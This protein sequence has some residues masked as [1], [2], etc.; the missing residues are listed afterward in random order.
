MNNDPVTSYGSKF[1]HKN[2]RRRVFKMVSVGVMDDAINSMYDVISISA[3][4]LNLSVTIMNT[5]TQLEIRFGTVFN[6]IEAATIAFFAV[7]YFLRLY[8][9]KCLYPAKNEIMAVLSYAISFSGIVDMLSFLPYYLPTFFPAGAAV[10]K[11]FRVARILRLFRIN[12]Y[13]DSLNVI[14]EV[15][16]RKKQQLL[17]SFFIIIV[18]MLAS[19][20]CMYS[21]ENQAQ[22]EVFKDAF[23]GIWWAVSTLLTV[24]YGDIYPITPIGRLMGI[25]IAFLG[26]TIIAIP[27]GIISAGFVEQYS[28][29]Q[30]FDNG[31]EA[32]VHFIKINLIQ[33]DKWIGQKIC[34]L[35]LPRGVIVAVVQ[36]DN[37]TIVPRGNLRLRQGDKLIMGADSIKGDKPV[38]LKEI[39]LKKNHR[40]NGQSIKDLNISRQSFIIM[41]KRGD[42][43]IIP[44]GDLILQQNDVIII[45][46]KT[47]QRIL[48]DSEINDT[49]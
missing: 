49:L 6:Y 29:F 15:I 12:A 8:T 39:T 9:A 42:Q 46:S 36:R 34:D 27:T 47:Q 3:L 45:Y 33:G 44:Y 35:S 23:S 1:N 4:I 24:G 48:S 20:L 17:S 30:S 18:L 14:T 7:D 22:P 43:T 38:Y 19:S 13:Y 2:L 41:I 37:E 16:L 31:T 32:N 21:L 25:I 11:M 5:F 40:W 26:V 10:F 28:K